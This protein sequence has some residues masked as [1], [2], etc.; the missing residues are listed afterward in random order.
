MPQKIG[1]VV[2]AA[3]D[4]PRSF[5]QQ[6]G[7][8]IMPINMQFGT[9]SFKDVRDPE[10]TMEF[11]RRYVAEKELEITTAPLSVKAIKDWFLDQ[12]VL[13]YDR[14]LVVTVSSTR[15]PVFENATKASFMILSGYKE[16]RRAAGLDEQF[17]L[18]VLDT[19]TL[20]TGQAVVVFEALRIL[21]SG[22]ADLAF[23]RLR[24]HVESFS[25]DVHAYLVPQDLYYVRSRAH[26]KG[27]KS[28]GWFKYQMGTM[29]DIKP[30]LK[31]YRGETDAV[32]TVRGFEKAVERLFKI[33][34][35]AVER[36]LLTKVVCMSYAGNPED[37][38][39]FP[40]YAEFIKLAHANKVETPLAVMSTV[41]G[42]HV[43][44]GAFSLAYAAK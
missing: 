36:G 28:V 1:I 16:R 30:I 3:C 40:G 4:L 39:A 44:P 10:Q 14:V 21:Q 31:V 43:G 33:A 20:F 15:S 27:D 8:E 26:Q 9:M 19:K 35:E 22:Q 17:A 2:D 25:Q 29:L 32:E 41:A 12:L 11:Y 37:V 42:I 24:Q 5:I 34:G 18:R 6:H 7:L 13:K 38:K 23:D